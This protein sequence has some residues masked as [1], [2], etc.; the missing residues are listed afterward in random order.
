MSAG[1][2]RAAARPLR[3]LLIEDSDEDA[4]L[5]Q[6]ELERAGYEPVIER[7][8]TREELAAA[9]E[10]G[11][12]DIVISDYRLPRFSAPEA[13]ALYRESGRDAPFLVCSGSIGEVQ[14]VELLKAGAADFFLK[15]HL[16]RLGTAIARELREAENR[17]ARAAMEER[18]RASLS[19]LRASEE[20][21]RRAV[22]TSPNGM[23]LADARGVITLVNAQ[24]EQM[25]GYD[26]SELLGRSVDL[27][28]PA[29]LRE[30]HAGHRDTFVRQE[31]SRHLRE[32]SGLRRDGT[33]FPVEIG[34][35]H[36]E[37]ADGPTV[38]AVLVDVTERRAFQTR[39]QQAQR[40][41]AIGRLAGGVAHDFNNLLG[42]ISGFA[43]LARRQVPAQHPV[44]A[45]LGQIL[46]ATSRA[47]DLTRQMLAFSRRQ[48]MRPRVLDLNTVVESAV[49]MLSRLIGED[50]EVVL[51][52]APDL[53]P[54]L[55]DPTQMDQVIMNLALN[56][57]DAMPHGGTLTFETTNVDLDDSYVR[58]HAAGQVGSYAM[59]AV[60][61]T[62]VGMNAETQAQIFE[63][64]FTTKPEGQGTGLGL[65]TVYG[66]VKQ[67]QGF[68]WVYSEPE[69][70]A[71]FK[72][73]LPR[74]T[75][76]EDASPLPTPAAV[77]GGTE[78]I[79]L[80]ED[81]EAL[82][83]VI[84]ETLEDQGYTVLPTANGLAALECSDRH[85]GRIH[86]LL[87]D[88]VMPG[89]NGRDLAESLSQRRPDM[90]V[91]F[92]SGYS[93]GMVTD[94]RLVASGVTLVEKP[95]TPTVLGQAIRRAL[96]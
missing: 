13:L 62:G 30:A 94:R 76:D 37:S 8:E 88:V 45:R 43:D 41:E 73:Y 84:C 79:L 69:H 46:S 64:F 39:M 19:A 1:D 16:A 59:L 22:E 12:F 15:G 72:V 48:V 60:A 11:L 34:L 96:Q 63:P 77:A 26:R 42:V 82:R 10:R 25:F 36:F 83:E 49:K 6:L 52:L 29:A 35:S 32:V 67:S 47:A 74:V 54:V 86:L 78:T 57:R 95:L 55:A 66:I 38:M 18:H 28:V 93:N 75:G 24:V 51:R 5:L 3:V 17:R 44:Q 89:M 65:A 71:T 58:R 9:V 33:V 70:G 85:Q 31:E 56:A 68:L 21:F 4:E 87:T 40:L 2:V 53:A 81:Q 14:A 92:M 61:D 20:R 91:V 27:L 7:V 50:I 23:L 80:V 90:R